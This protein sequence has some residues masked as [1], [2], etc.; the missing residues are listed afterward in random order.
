MPAKYYTVGPGTLKLGETGTELDLSCQVTTATVEWDSDQ[1][2]AVDTLC[3][4]SIAGETSFT[5]TLKGTALQDLSTG[6]IAD[7]TWQHKG[8]DVPFTYTPNTQVGATIKGK[9]T[10]MPV[11]VGGDVKSRPDTDFEFPCVGEPELTPATAD[12]GDS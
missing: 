4:D 11:S 10:I 8:K 5:A 2:D 6:G 9:C 12:R 7:Y 1:D 3:G